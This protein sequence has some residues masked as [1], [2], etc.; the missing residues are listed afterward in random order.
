LTF[1][2]ASKIVVTSE[3]TKNLIAKKYQK[4]TSVKL[5][6]AQSNEVV[7]SQHS[8][9]REAISDNLVK[10]L[11][12]GRFEYW[13]GVQIC[14]KSLVD[15]KYNYSEMNVRLTLIG[16]GVYKKELQTLAKV[17]GVDSMID[18]HSW[19]E[20]SKLAEFYSSHDVFLF[21]S[22]HDSGGMVVLEALAASMPVICLNL[23][24]PATIIT[25]S[26]GVVI[27][28]NLSEEKICQK[29]ALEIFIITRAENYL[30]YCE[31]ARKRAQEFTWEKLVV[32]LL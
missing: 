24:G 26:S 10:L 4:K 18:W 3:Q 20:Q 5:A 9:M 11:F 12:I 23:G 22:L 21:P 14:I 19:M 16:E 28:S 13:K 32:E 30:R 6:I 1:F 17:L 31:N 29:I 25:E 2:K 15:L 7:S 8:V 27:D